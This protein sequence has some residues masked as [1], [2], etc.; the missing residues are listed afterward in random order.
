VTPVISKSVIAPVPTLLVTVDVA[1]AELKEAWCRLDAVD[2]HIELVD[3]AKHCLQLLPVDR[4]RDAGEVARRVSLYSERLETQLHEAEL[5]A[6]EAQTLA[7][8][9]RKRRHIMVVATLLMAITLCVAGWSLWRYAVQIERNAA[10]NYRGLTVAAYHDFESGRFVQAC[11][12]LD[13]APEQF[14]NWEWH[15]LNDQTDQSTMTI[16]TEA[17]RIPL[18][19]FA[20]GGELIVSVYSD[21]T[22]HHWNRSSGA[23]V[24]SASPGAGSPLAMDPTG[25]LVLSL[26][27]GNEKL[28][29][30]KADN[31]EVL[32]EF[33][34]APYIQDPKLSHDGSHLAFVSLLAN[35]RTKIEL[36][37]VQSGKLVHSFEDHYLP[38][39]VEDRNWLVTV[40]GNAV[41][42]W[43]LAAGKPARPSLSLEGLRLAATSAINRDG[44]LLAAQ[45]IRQKGILVWDLETGE[46]N[47]EALS[48]MYSTALVFDSTGTQLLS[49]TQN[50]TIQVWNLKTLEL[51][52]TVRFV[53]GYAGGIHEAS[54]DGAAFL[55]F[56]NR[57]GRAQIR[58]WDL[59]GNDVRVLRGHDSY[60]YPVTVSPNGDVIASGSWDTTVRIWD[61]RTG[62]EIVV[63]DEHNAMVYS[64]VFDSAGKRLVSASGD[65]K[66]I[67]WDT[68]TYTVSH[69]MDLNPAKAY[70]AAFS[71]D[72]SL[73]VV[74]CG[75]LLVFDGRTY[76]L[77][78][79]IRNKDLSPLDPTFVTAVEFSPSG[80]EFI[81]YR[82]KQWMP[83]RELTVWDASTLEMKEQVR[84]PF[85][86]VNVVSYSAD[87]SQIAMGHASGKISLW[88]AGNFDR[89][90]SEIQ[91]HSEEVFDIAFLPDGSRLVTAGHDHT[92]RLWDTE[93]HRQ[94]AVLR[95][96]N[97]YVF[98]LAI[99]QNGQRIVSSSGDGTVRIWE[100]TPLRDRL[101]SMSTGESLRGQ[102]ESLVEEL[103]EKLGESELVVEQL[104]QDDELSPA[105]RRQAMFAVARHG[106]E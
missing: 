12:L 42:F 6:V 66:V 63:L 69:E 85:E 77:K 73:L 97:D 82:G 91:G 14:R 88:H 68:E 86:H 98:S 3:L 21:N 2:G 27:A 94:L 17:D 103:F 57:D 44:S 101:E 52:Q 106:R 11:E 83:N 105:L 74:A 90:F 70:T 56:V 37:D 33:P 93:R 81:S 4:P 7:R 54:L 102:A 58:V 49:I 5:A 46:S 62:A 79:E 32:G 16:E 13:Q 24:G 26:R 34:A 29:L 9:E 96:H 40:A 51:F 35:A 53:N 89:P 99:S 38:M 72:E 1:E 18:T 47:D 15:Y 64:L 65:G 61:A 30:W 84:P 55:S 23:H 76:E 59:R 41:H 20:Q 71:S 78:K 45:L 104:R 67:V 39:F 75:G 87:G 95:G 8:E 28:V 80:D 60:V 92:I 50:G 43:D 22:A 10:E 100:S 31:G 48:R 19:G 36:Y 25:R